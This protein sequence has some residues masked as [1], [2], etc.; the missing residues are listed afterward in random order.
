MYTDKTKVS[1]IPK[2]PVTNIQQ[3]S[4]IS[5]LYSNVVEE[6]AVGFIG[7]IGI[8]L[9]ISTILSAVG[10]F[11]FMGFLKSRESGLLAEIKEK[12]KIIDVNFIK[13]AEEMSSRIKEAREIL[14]NQVL[15]TRLFHAL[16]QNTISAVQYESLSMDQR[17]DKGGSTTSSDQISFGNTVELAGKAESYR[18]LAQQSEVFLKSSILKDH[19]F[20]DFKIDEFTNNVTFKLSISLPDL[21]KNTDVNNNTASLNTNRQGYIDSRDSSSAV[22][23]NKLNTKKNIFGGKL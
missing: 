10:I 16:E 2:A 13:S 22:S 4:S 21:L 12:E 11:L 7:W 9:L 5:G 1:F 8:I 3:P 15:A 20:S 18:S 23:L 14:D 6:K 17:D 19:F